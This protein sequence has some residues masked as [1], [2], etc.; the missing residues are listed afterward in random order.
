LVNPNIEAYKKW[1]EE[2]TPRP[3]DPW[4][5]WTESQKKVGLIVVAL[6]ILALSGRK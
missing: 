6:V 5:I 1:L 4:N 2:N 3:G